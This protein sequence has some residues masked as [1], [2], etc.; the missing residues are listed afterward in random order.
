MKW[1]GKVRMA[2]IGLLKENTD[3]DILIKTLRKTEYTNFCICVKFKTR[4][5][6]YIPYVRNISRQNRILIF[7]KCSF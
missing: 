1:S 5:I 6:L 4:F 7:R 2:G 3:R